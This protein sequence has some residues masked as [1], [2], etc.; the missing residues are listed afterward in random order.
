MV[1]NATFQVLDRNAKQEHLF[2]WVYEF[3]S[4]PAVALMKA[5]VGAALFST[6]VM[7]KKDSRQ[8]NLRSKGSRGKPIVKRRSRRLTVSKHVSWKRHLTE[9]ERGMHGATCP[10]YSGLR[11]GLVSFVRKGILSGNG[12]ACEVPNFQRC[13]ALSLFLCVRVSHSCEK[14]VFF[15]FFLHICFSCS[16]EVE[17]SCTDRKVQINFY[18]FYFFHLS[19]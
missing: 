2:L 13:L 6:P 10:Y 19:R 12:S 9:R 3:H 8:K 14:D 18:C 15:F 1:V 16:S 17:A 7:V 11:Q 5:S 4:S